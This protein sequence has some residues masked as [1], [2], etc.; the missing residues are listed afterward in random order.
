VLSPRFTATKGLLAFLG[1]AIL[2]LLF[3]QGPLDRI[4]ES[5]LAVQE[6]EGLAAADISSNLPLEDGSIT[7]RVAPPESDAR[8]SFAF[9]IWSNTETGVDA[10]T[11]TARIVL[12]GG[13]F[14]TIRS[15]DD[16]RVRLNRGVPFE[17]LTPRQ[18]EAVVAYIRDRESERAQES[19]TGLSGEELELTDIAG[20]SLYVTLNWSFDLNGYVQEFQC[21]FSTGAVWSSTGSDFRLD[22]P[23]SSWTWTSNNGNFEGLNPSAR[24]VID[25]TTDLTMVQ[26][27]GMARSTDERGVDEVTWSSTA[28]STEIGNDTE[29]QNYEGL[30]ATF[31]SLSRERD[32]QDDLFIGG[33]ALGLVGSLVIGGVALLLDA[34]SAAFRRRRTS[35]SECQA[36]SSA[37]DAQNRVDTPSVR[38]PASAVAEDVTPDSPIAKE[39]VEPASRTTEERAPE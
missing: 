33:V 37:S 30:S 34:T 10:G 16:P 8:S 12:A 15:C 27:G 22:V 3:V 38:Q 26:S 17:K 39:T 32:E 25:G 20:E 31:T 19:G 21:S 11:G 28:Y 1:A 9:S 23:R 6:P 2:W 24:V 35:E 29:R 14:E 5:P 4:R 18:K 36:Y 7:Y 13:Q